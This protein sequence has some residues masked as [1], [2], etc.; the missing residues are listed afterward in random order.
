MSP[1][2][3]TTP[4]RNAM[5]GHGLTDARTLVMSD[6]ELHPKRQGLSISPRAVAYSVYNPATE[7]YSLITL[8]G[9]WLIPGKDGYK[10]RGPVKSWA[11]KNVADVRPDGLVILEPVRHNGRYA[12]TRYGQRRAGI[13]RGTVSYGRDGYTCHCGAVLTWSDVAR[14]GWVTV[15]D[16]RR[17]THVQA[18]ALDSEHAVEFGAE[19]CRYDAPVAFGT[20]VPDAVTVPGEVPAEPAADP[21]AG[22][23]FVWEE[24]GRAPYG[25]TCHVVT[26]DGRWRFQVDV[27]KKDRVG[28]QTYSAPLHM[29]HGTTDNLGG[30]PQSGWRAGAQVADFQSYSRESCEAAISA[31]VDAIK[32]R[33]KR[34]AELQAAGSVPRPAE[35]S[36]LCGSCRIKNPHKTRCDCDGMG[37]NPWA[38]GEVRRA[39]MARVFKACRKVAKARA[40]GVDVPAGHLGWSVPQSRAFAPTDYAAGTMVA[41][42]VEGTPYTGQVWSELVVTGDWSGTSYASEAACVIVA[43][44]DGRAATRAEAVPVPLWH[45]SKNKTPYAR[46]SVPNGMNEYGKPQRYSADVEVIAPDCAADGLFAVEDMPT[47]P[48]PEPMAAPEPGCMRDITPVAA[49]ALDRDWWRGAYGQ[50]T[51]STVRKVKG[52]PAAMLR[53]ARAAESEG[54]AVALRCG[55]YDP[56]DETSVGVWEVEATGRCHDNA[57]VGLADAVLSAMWVQPEGRKRWAFSE[58]LSGAEIG[59]RILTGIVTLADFEHNAR[60]GRPLSASQ[61]AEMEAKKREAQAEREREEAERRAAER[62]EDVANVARYARDYEGADAAAAEQFGAW[63]ADGETLWLGD[64]REAFRN[65]SL[66]AADAAPAP[67]PQP[68]PA[69]SAAA[70]EERAVAAG[71]K[72][73]AADER[74]MAGLTEARAA[75]DASGRDAAA[76][77]TAVERLTVARTRVA[78][79]ESSARRSHEDTK[80]AAWECDT[81]TAWQLSNCAAEALDEV[82]QASRHTALSVEN[83]TKDREAGRLGDYLAECERVE[84][85]AA[86][87]ETAEAEGRSFAAL[88]AEELEA[89][90]AAEPG[91]ADEWLTEYQHAPAAE[92][93]EPETEPEAAE[94]NEYPYP[95]DAEEQFTAGVEA[96]RLPVDAKG[97]AVRPGHLMVQNFY[98]QIHAYRVEKVFKNGNWLAVGVRTEEDGSES[99]LIEHTNLLAIVTAES[100]AALVLLDVRAG[101]HRGRIAQSLVSSKAGKFRVQCEC[102]GW[103]EIVEPGRSRAIAW[104]S[105]V[106]EARAGFEQHAGAQ[107][108]EESPRSVGVPGAVADAESA[109]AAEAEGAEAEGQS[110]AALAAETLEAAGAA[111]AEPEPEPVA[112]PKARR[113]VTV[114]AVF[115][116]KSLPTRL[117]DAGIAYRAE[118][119]AEQGGRLVY[120]IGGCTMTPGE[121]DEWLTEYQ[122]AP[123]AEE[124]EPET[125]AEPV[126]V[127]APFESAVGSAA[128]PDP[129][130]LLTAEL[131]GLA[132]RW[133]TV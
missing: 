67:E 114:S 105:T 44:V 124:T 75:R 66:R 40:A 97:R 123:A 21:V 5:E 17:G 11:R 125:V 63:V 23:G 20:T 76:W 119:L 118:T 77:V 28:T 12:T 15:T 22:K 6:A 117:T 46:V 107:I 133:A 79:A 113:A 30:R 52:V 70:P 18:Y 62:A 59:G 94:A 73:K 93:A 9:R 36:Q 102:E 129:F 81:E 31:H 90:R 92:V 7:R 106:E 34:H 51:L 85:A 83:A 72:R 50:W 116:R 64:Y 122:H 126:E 71:G 95:E 100:V 29:W 39:E 26:V 8:D 14:D 110:F 25:R 43:T 84:S 89:A 101:E 61:V 54:W 57:T 53:F 37:L 112:V 49:V 3:I 45:G 38:S 130:D 103:D 24:E 10:T 60:M 4:A 98:E 80:A 78:V 33:E 127:V 16:G 32:A 55:S 128:E 109:P 41:W 108:V 2:L 35:Y 132:D 120:V 86:E 88:A 68:A 104:F 121:A 87:A 82:R 91:E 65:W 111:E 13:C 131:A 58:E 27:S 56:D 42:E 99:R 19:P 69:E 115:T 47:E 1:E 74:G 96:W 48:E